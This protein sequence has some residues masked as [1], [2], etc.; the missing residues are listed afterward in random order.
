MTERD[1]L[2]SKS[3]AIEALRNQPRYNN[4]FV[5]ITSALSALAALPVLET[6]KEES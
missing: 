4:S 1:P 3:Q 2:I 6:K 5:T